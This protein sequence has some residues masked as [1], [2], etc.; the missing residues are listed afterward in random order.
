MPAPN[1]VV[2]KNGWYK[3]EYMDDKWTDFWPPNDE[4]VFVEDGIITEGK[5][6]FGVK[7]MGRKVVITPEMEKNMVALTF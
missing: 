1:E 6:E 4:F 2:M 5:N 7:T 3:V